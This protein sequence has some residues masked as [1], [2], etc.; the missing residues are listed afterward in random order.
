[1][2]Q[3]VNSTIPRGRTMDLRRR[4]LVMAAVA[5]LAACGSKEGS[6]PAATAAPAAP[7]VQ[8]DGSKVTATAEEVARAARGSLKCPPA[9]ATPARAA[10]S[11][12]DDIVGVRPGLTYDEAAALVTC[13]NELLVVSE[14]TRRGFQVQTY[15]QKLRQG[16]NARFAEA[17]V[18][19]TSKQIMAEMQDAAMARGTNRRVRDV[20]PGQAKWYVA[21]MG[22][23]GQERVLSAAREEW[24][25]EGRNPTRASVEQALQDKYGKPTQVQDVSGSSYLRWAYDPLGRLVTETSPLF[26]QCN[27]QANPDAGVNLTPDCGIV[28]AAEVGPLDT[29]PDLAQYL[30]V[31]VVDQ[32][33]GYDSLTN[34]EQALQAMESQR[35]ARQVQDASRN[36]DAPTL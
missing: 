5:T 36:A 30:R 25:A 6:E 15:G 12:V 32:A 21:T 10:G 26:N 18:E 3:R 11:P 4:L 7:A 22:L 9:V 17:K 31:S 27:A 16:F 20:L 2:V 33:G 28:V 14:D 19:K 13:S 8:A 29:N 34:T 35:R 1:M 24:F 23:P